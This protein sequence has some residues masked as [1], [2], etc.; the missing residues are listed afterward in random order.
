MGVRAWLGR[1]DS[2]QWGCLGANDTGE[3]SAQKFS[4][5]PQGSQ[6]CIHSGP[7][8]FYMCMQIPHGV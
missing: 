7:P 2:G 4:G 3:M 5:Y 8:G 1:G 6:A